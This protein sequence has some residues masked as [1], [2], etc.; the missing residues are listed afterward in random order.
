MRPYGVGFRG[1]QVI[2]VVRGLIGTQEVAAAATGTPL[3]GLVTLAANQFVDVPKI[4]ELP[5]KYKAIIEEDQKV[6]RSPVGLLFNYSKK[7]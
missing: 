2:P 3:F 6:N 4:K 1:W 7:L 5:G